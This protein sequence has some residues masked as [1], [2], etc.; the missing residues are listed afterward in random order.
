LKGNHH[1]KPKL[2]YLL[3]SKLISSSLRPIIGIVL[4][5][6]ISAG[7]IMASG[8]SPIVAYVALVQGAVGSIASFA[9]TC[10]R[11]SP[12]LLAALGVAI[13]F[14]A[15]MLNVGP[16]GQMYAGAAAATAIGLISFSTSSWIHLIICIF[17]GFLGGVVWALIP[18]YLR[19]Y[20]DVSEVVITLMLNYIGIYFVSWLVHEPKL[21]FEKGAAYPQSPLIM[22]SA[23][24]PILIKNTNLHAGILLG[25]FFA[26]LLY[27]LLQHTSFGF[28]IKMVGENPVAARY[29]GINVKKYLFT[30][31]LISGGFGGLAGA[32][33]ILGLKLRLF[34][35][36]VSGV[37]YE[38]IAV[39]LL[40][41]CNFIGTIFSAFFF[42]ALKAGATKMQIV[43]GIETSMAL[44][45]L[46][47]AL[48]FV[49]AMGFENGKLFSIKKKSK[50]DNL[51]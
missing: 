28:K 33:E 3:I 36:F 48:I 40:A 41:N 5:L 51:D 30:A 20:K 9:N 12:L 23:R 29:A 10:V 8:V 39:A 47:L 24:L 11:T 35:L 17:A 38:T 37:G 43:S 25:V 6:I 7:M 21:L 50:L 42:G 19:A 45:V 44:V 14:K 22:K 16:E 46:S 13:G 34:D 31:M 2:Y 27:I 32:V 18:A 26:I 49:I 4:A 1:Q 15:G